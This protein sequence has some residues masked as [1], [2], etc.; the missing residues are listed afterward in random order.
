MN[1]VEPFPKTSQ[2]NQYTLV[3]NGQCVDLTRAI[4]TSKT[5]ATYILKIYF[6]SWIASYAVSMY[7]LIDYGTQFVN[8]LLSTMHTLLHVKN[9]ITTA[10]CPQSDDETKR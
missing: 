3:K 4:L 1:I 5:T 6:D 10:Y 2:C 9:F 7:T 8:K